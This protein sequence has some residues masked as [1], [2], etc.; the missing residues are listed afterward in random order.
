MPFHRVLSKNVSGLLV[1]RLEAAEQAQNHELPVAY[2]VN[3][4]A[5]RKALEDRWKSPRVRVR[6]EDST[7]VFD[8]EQHGRGAALAVLRSQFAGVVEERAGEVRVRVPVQQTRGL[9][10]NYNHTLKQ[11][12]KGAATTVIGRGRD[13]EPLYQHYQQLLAEGTKPNLAKLTIA[14]QIASICLSMWRSEEVYDPAKL[15]K[16]D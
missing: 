3:R 12:F 16:M 13:E 6:V 8:R 2:S 15:K 14:R 7:L 9:N 10:R 1:K 4:K 11:I 5:V